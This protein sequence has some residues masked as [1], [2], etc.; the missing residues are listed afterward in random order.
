M[1]DYWL[2]NIFSSKTKQFPHLANTSGRKIVQLCCKN[3]TRSDDDD[4]REHIFYGV[5][6]N[7]RAASRH[8]NKP[9]RSKKK[10]K[11]NKNRFINTKPIRGKKR[12]GESRVDGWL[13][14]IF[15]SLL[16]LVSFFFSFFATISGR[17]SRPCSLKLF[18]GLMPHSATSVPKTCLCAS[19]CV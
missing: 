2:G 7:Q 13:D 17:K 12:K 16:P 10:K 8:G 15:I 9:S 5:L 6:G 14:F 3:P 1:N 18:V 4:G 19:E 11:I